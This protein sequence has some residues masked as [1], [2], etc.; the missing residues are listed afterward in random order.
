M[1]PGSLRPV[2]LQMVLHSVRGGRRASLFERLPSS[3]SSAADVAGGPVK[4]EFQ[5]SDEWLVYVLCNT[6]VGT[7]TLEIISSHLKL[8][9]HGV[10]SI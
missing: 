2:W 7:L 3:V 1:S 5:E 9:R 8:K 10:P 6:H 4:S